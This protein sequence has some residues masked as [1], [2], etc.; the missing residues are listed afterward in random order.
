MG[1]LKAIRSL[2]VTEEKR[3]FYDEDYEQTV[4]NYDENNGIAESDHVSEDNS[5]SAFESELIN[6]LDRELNSEADYDKEDNKEESEKSQT[7]IGALKKGRGRQ[8]DISLGKK[9]TIKEVGSFVESNCEKMN[10]SHTQNKGLKRE[11]EQ[12]TGYLKDI[13]L[14]DNMEEEKKE[15]LIG[16]AVEIVEL[17]KE[18]KKQEKRQRTINDANYKTMQQYENNMNQE[19]VSLKKKEQFQMNIKS[20]MRHLE[21]EKTGLLYEKKEWVRRSNMFKTASIGVSFIVISVFVFLLILALYSKYDMTFPFIIAIAVSG[22]L[23]LYLFTE[24]RK[25]RYQASLADKKINKAINLM[26]RVKIKYINNTALLDY[27]YSKYGVK[28]AEELEYIWGQYL[29]LK[30]EEEKNLSNKERIEELEKQLMD[31]LLAEGIRD[32]GV[33]T[34]QVVALIESREMVE[35]RHKLN[36]RRGK[37]RE[38]IAY[39][40]D[41]FEQSA[42]PLKALMEDK[43]E[44]RHLV[45]ECLDRYELTEAFD[46]VFQ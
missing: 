24:I 30:A 1:L 15:K 26:N 23:I 38:Q 28:S 46:M 32:T 18:R 3:L 25:N 17:N 10:T 33:W 12:V 9:P 2:F 44:Y 4:D 37:L 35:V 16:L 42:I 13:E 8:E 20:D 39:N 11:Y 45:V 6:E 34:S 40:D 41:V 36:V 29:K 14:I 27:L 22:L 31:T 43:D 5:E 7:V 19:L 21:G